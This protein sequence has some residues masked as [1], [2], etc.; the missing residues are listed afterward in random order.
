M[1]RVLLASVLCFSPLGAYGAE[2]NTSTTPPAAPE[3][4]TVKDEA[5][6]LQCY[7]ALH[8]PAPAGEGDKTATTPEVLSAKPTDPPKK[9]D[10][11]DVAIAPNKYKG[12]NLELSKLQCFYA[13]KDE[14]RC[15]APSSDVVLVV[16]GTAVTPDAE[17]K[18]LEDD[19]GEIKKLETAA[20]RR[21]IH[22]VPG[23]VDH[24]TIG[25]RQRTIVISKML[26]IVPPPAAP[27]PVAVRRRR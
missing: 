11:D 26:E 6:R 25:L 27:A 16:I 13:D 21:T 18:K 23:A 3:C 14:Y 17:R 19:C 2:T 15:L 5:L 1:K 20:C 22:F 8:A 10:A 4:W 24:D 7:D 9:V 12:K